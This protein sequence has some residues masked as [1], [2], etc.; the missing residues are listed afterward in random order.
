M[1]LGGSN[2]VNKCYDSFL[3]TLQAQYYKCFPKL[4]KH[5]KISCN[6][7]KPWITPAILKSINK[8]NKFYRVWLHKRTDSSVIKYKKYKN[9]LTSIKRAAEKLYY[10]NEFK[11]IEGEIKK[12]WRLIKKY[13]NNNADKSSNIKEIYLNNKII[14]K[15]EDIANA[16]NRFFINIGL[17]LDYKTKS[18]LGN[19]RKFI[20]EYT[21][22]IYIYPTN[23]N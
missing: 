14:S 20:Q 1:D 17:N 13:I 3:E 19:Y 12:T 23:V 9:K 18:I 2:N 6:K 5:I 15:F 22:S 16:F 10:S 8:K 21:S 11:E 4:T 7:H